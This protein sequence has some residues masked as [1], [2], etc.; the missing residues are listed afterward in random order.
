ML[1]DKSS[2]YPA[3]AAAPATAR[4]TPPLT[5]GTVRIWDRPVR[6]V[7]WAIALLV[8][9]AW[10]AAGTGHMAWHY[11]LGYALLGLVIFR[12][13]WGFAGSSTTRFGSFV[14][15]PR[16]VIECLRGGQ[17]Y[18]HGHIRLDAQQTWPPFQWRPNTAHA[19]V[20]SMSASASTTKASAPPS[21]IVDFFSALP[22]WAATIAPAP[23][24]PV[25]ATPWTR[26]SSRIRPICARV[27]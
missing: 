20:L 22:A 8:P 18:F 4:L 3:S 23:S 26:G 15:S 10:W 9:L 14:R 6:S 25:S 17:G 13:I 2:D 7:H 24:D 1:N 11:R 21:S 27:A 12:L 19:T 5:R 16:R